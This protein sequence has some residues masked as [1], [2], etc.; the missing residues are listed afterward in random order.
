VE[1]V[2]KTKMLAGFSVTHLNFLRGWVIIEI[3]LLDLK[4]VHPSGTLLLRSGITSVK[5]YS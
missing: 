1:G 5:T 2:L 3:E 4:N